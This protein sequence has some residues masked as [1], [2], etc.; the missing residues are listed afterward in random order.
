MITDD[1][2][3]IDGFATGDDQLADKARF[4]ERIKA[5]PPPRTMQD[6]DRNVRTFGVEDDVAIVNGSVKDSANASDPGGIY[7]AIYLRNW[8]KSWSLARYVVSP[9]LSDP[10]S[11]ERTPAEP[12]SPDALSASQLRVMEVLRQHF[13][14][15]A[16]RDNAALEKTI[17]DDF[18]YIRGGA[19]GGNQ[20]GK[21]EYMAFKKTNTGAPEMVAIDKPDIQFYGNYGEVAVVTGVR[22]DATGGAV[23][24]S[25]FKP[26]WRTVAYYVAV[27][28][29]PSTRS[30]LWLLEHYH[31]A[32]MRP[33]ATTAAPAPAATQ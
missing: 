10:F 29:R 30:N 12:W 23:F 13:D 5:A 31:A 17:G 33:A 6:S 16:R 2:K 9:I 26:K 1:A 21:A 28:L 32:F 8:D 18:W 25:D 7:T 27:V 11:P 3:F 14:A 20:H 22:R 19:P 15:M 4:L 24:G